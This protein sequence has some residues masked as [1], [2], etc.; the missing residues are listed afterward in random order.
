M[1]FFGCCY[2]LSEGQTLTE[3]AYSDYY[4][5]DQEYGLHREKA[6]YNLSIY[7]DEKTLVW[8]ADDSFALDTCMVIKSTRKYVIAQSK[9]RTKIFYSIADQRIFYLRKWGSTWTVY[10]L[11]KGSFGVQ[12]LLTQIM[13]LL[14]K[15][16]DEGEV[17]EFLA[18]QHQYDF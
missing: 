10:G 18:Q 5:F 2:F 17:M 6:D 15:G 7:S 8:K 13:H 11:G 4:E 16:G 3:I 9:D 12:E 14:K 1:I